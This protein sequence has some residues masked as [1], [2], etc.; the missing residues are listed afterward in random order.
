VIKNDRRIARLCLS[1]R[2][3]SLRPTH[4]SSPER[5]EGSGVLPRFAPPCLQGS[6]NV[7]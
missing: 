6:Q 7:Q 5:G 3:L 4:K 2:D 1:N